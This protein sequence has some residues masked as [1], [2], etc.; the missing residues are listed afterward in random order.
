MPKQKQWQKPGWSGRVLLLTFTPL[1]LTGLWDGEGKVWILTDVK[2]LKMHLNTFFFYYC[3]LKEIWILKS[4]CSLKSPIHAEHNTKNEPTENSKC[5]R[6]CGTIH[7]YIRNW[8]VCVRA[9]VRVICKLCTSSNVTVS[10]VMLP[11][12][13]LNHIKTWRWSTEL[14][15]NWFAFLCSNPR[16]VFWDVHY[17]KRMQRDCH[18][19][20]RPGSR[21]N[22]WYCWRIYFHARG[23]LSGEQLP[24]T[25]SKLYCLTI[26]FYRKSLPFFCW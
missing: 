1:W 23:H 20:T 9:R 14:T 22:A 5:L 12:A 18:T 16:P 7:V 8:C 26:F 15:L 24:Q 4:G 2:S 25:L 21:H 11:T 6:V 19:A 17:D 13:R 3:F 10:T